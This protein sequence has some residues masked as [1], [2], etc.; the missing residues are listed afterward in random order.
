MYPKYTVVHKDTIL[1]LYFAD[2]HISNVGGW[3]ETNKQANDIQPS[4]SD[5]WEKAK[6]KQIPWI[7]TIILSSYFSDYILPYC[8]PIYLT[9]HVLPCK[10][11]CDICRNGN[12]FPQDI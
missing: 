4:H 10:I 7:L 11:H 2:S 12:H 1:N 6:T 8:L 9:G 5:K 3:Q